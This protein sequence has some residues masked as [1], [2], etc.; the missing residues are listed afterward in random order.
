MNAEP[1]TRRLLTSEEDSNEVVFDL[2]DAIAFELRRGDDD[3]AVIEDLNFFVS[4]ER[5]DSD[6][7]AM[8]IDFEN[9][10]QVSIGTKP[11]AIV[12]E[13]TDAYFFSKVD[14]PALI[15]QGT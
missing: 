12:A 7:M 10:G 13:I 3:S 4:V 1:A 2:G 8:K 9:P 14:E 6:E 15:K 5:R 11:D